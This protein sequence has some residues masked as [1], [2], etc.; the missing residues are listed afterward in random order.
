MEKGRNCSLKYILNNEWA[1]YPK[2]VSNKVI[3][4]IGGLYGNFFALEKIKELAKLERDEPLLVFNGDIHWFDILEKDFLNIENI[5]KKDIKLLGNVEYELLNEEDLFGCG[6]NYPEDVDEGIVN[7]SNIIHSM[8]KNNIKDKI[9]LDDIKNRDKTICL[10]VMNKNIAVT[11]GDEKNMAGW[12][13]SIDNLKLENRREELANWFINNNI[14][15]LATTHTCLPV[16]TTIKSSVVINNGSSGMAN[17]QNETYGIITRIAENSHPNNIVSQKI[18]NIFIELVKVDFNI[19]EFINWFDKIWDKNSPA[20]I[21][22]R[23]RIVNGTK[24]NVNNI[25]LENSSNNSC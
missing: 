22:Y 16:I 13:C 12:L 18:D 25:N 11:H 9:V 3:Y 17:V 8:M 15:V 20:S 2:E 24:L 10:S 19:D 6:C 5:I 1:K 7:R 4:I 14:D 21:S 23:N